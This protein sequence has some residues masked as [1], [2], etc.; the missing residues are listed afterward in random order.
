M[1]SSCPR[2][3]IRSRVLA[4]HRHL[5]QGRVLL[6][7]AETHGTLKTCVLRLGQKQQQRRRQKAA[8]DEPKF[9]AQNNIFTTDSDISRHT[10]P[11]IPRNPMIEGD[12]GND[13][14][15]YHNPFEDLA[16]YRTK[17]SLVQADRV[18]HGGVAPSSRESLAAAEVA[19]AAA[20]AVRR[21]GS[22]RSNN[23]SLPSADTLS[24]LHS[25][26]SQ[27]SAADDFAFMT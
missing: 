12:G 24:L 16:E 19:K 7:R 13:P 27:L 20:D 4:V 11:P 6:R 18:R 3:K 10:P 9:K 21:P 26:R 23:G 17:K 8:V 14:L 15:D 25:P 1:P 2:R 22:V 5:P